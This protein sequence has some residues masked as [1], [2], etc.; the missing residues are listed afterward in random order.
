M[1]QLENGVK[2]P[3]KPNRSNRY[4]TGL[5]CTFADRPERC[6]FF[7]L[8][9]EHREFY[10]DVCNLYELEG[11]DWIVHRTGGGGF[12]FISPTMITKEHWLAMHE[13]LQEINKECPMTTLRMEPNKYENEN[14]FWY[15]S[16]TEVLNA[17][18]CDNNLQMCNYLNRI[19]G[20]KFIGTGAGEM[21][22]V[23]YPLPLREGEI[24]L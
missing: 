4:T 14:Q 6:F 24:P 9:K 11:L 23:R 13:E 18:T 3:L 5:V 15:N 1:R 7:E 19:F 12:H 22:T 2:F 8:D 20:S 10:Q 21:K 16:H 17:P